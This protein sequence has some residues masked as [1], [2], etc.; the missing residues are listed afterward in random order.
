M[1]VGSYASH[2]IGS[3]LWV[4]Y[5]SPRQEP[6]HKISVPKQEFGNKNRGALVAPA[7]CR[8]KHRLEA[9]ATNKR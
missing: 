6:G 1:R 4:G 8:C 5:I 7:S 3:W 9:C 2:F